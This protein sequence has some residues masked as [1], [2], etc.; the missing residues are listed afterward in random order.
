MKRELKRYPLDYSILAGGGI[1]GL[2]LFWLAWPDVSLQRRILLTLCGLYP[3]WGLWHHGHRHKVTSAIIAEYTAVSV[4]LAT[5]VWII[6]D[7]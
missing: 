4:F 6:L 1:A 2:M 3:V 7:W 5:I